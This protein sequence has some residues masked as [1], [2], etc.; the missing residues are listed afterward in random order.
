[1][2]NLFEYHKIMMTLVLEWGPSTARG[3]TISVTQHQTSCQ[4]L[5]TCILKRFKENILTGLPRTQ[6]L[7]RDKSHD[8]W[9][10][11]KRFLAMN[12]FALHVFFKTLSLLTE[13]VIGVEGLPVP[14]SHVLNP[15][16]IS[17]FGLLRE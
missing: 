7:I 4:R 8:V 14:R 12:V 6:D 16:D 11:R 15:L 13:N 3:L 1:M 5:I 10:S 17:A 2:A 9:E